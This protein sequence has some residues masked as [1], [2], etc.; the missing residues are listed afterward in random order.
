MITF[1]KE[2]LR[3]LLRDKFRGTITPLLQRWPVASDTPH[4]ITIWRWLNKDSVRISPERVLGLA[5]VFDI[6]P[7]ALFSASPQEHAELCRRLA[8]SIGRKEA[9]GFSS[10]LQ[11]LAEFVVPNE[12]WPPAHLATT[13]FRRPWEVKSFRHSARDRVNYFQHLLITASPRE[14][15]EPQVWHFAFRSPNSIYPT[16]TP[17]GFVERSPEHAALFHFRGHSSTVALSR[18]GKS[19]IVQTWFGPGAA[20]FRVASLHGFEL[21]LRDAPHGLPCVRFP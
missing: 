8:A 3:R 12:N 18:S 19:F 6:D 11:W 21:S 5:G 17:Y 1:R 10:E 9:A 20:D 14:H 13:Y 16:W 15:G 2:L 7:T 4:R